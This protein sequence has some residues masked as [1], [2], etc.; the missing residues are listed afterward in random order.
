LAKESLFRSIYEEIGLFSKVEETSGR[1]QYQK[2]PVGEL[3]ERHILFEDWYIHAEAG[4][5]GEV[6]GGLLGRREAHAF[7]VKLLSKATNMEEQ[8]WTEWLSENQDKN[9]LA[10]ITNVSWLRDFEDGEVNWIPEWDNEFEGSEFEEINGFRGILKNG[11]KE[12]PIITNYMGGDTFFLVFIDLDTPGRLRILP[13]DEDH[14]EE[15]DHIGFDFYDL[16]NPD[17]WPEEIVDAVEEG[18]LEKEKTKKQFW[19]KLLVKQNFDTSENF[20]AY[21]FSRENSE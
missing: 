7:M 2:I 21:K 1:I 16:A 3:R 20:E 19:L 12:I 18:E 13:P 6:I 17:D 4:Q 9:L 15:I 14:D 5:F 11:E 10:I 8:N